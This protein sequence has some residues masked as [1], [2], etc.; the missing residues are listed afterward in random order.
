MYACVYVCIS[1]VTVLEDMDILIT[2]RKFALPVLFP[3][4]CLN[5]LLTT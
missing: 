5:L 4:R 2:A 1:D 3:L